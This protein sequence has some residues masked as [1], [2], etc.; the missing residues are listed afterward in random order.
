MAT[1]GLSNVSPEAQQEIAAL[2]ADGNRKGAALRLFQYRSNEE[3]AFL[4][5][6]N[7]KDLRLEGRT[8]SLIVLALLIAA[9]ILGTAIWLKLSR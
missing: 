1:A 4:I 8:R 2:L 7:R 3:R 5:R 9:L 6:E